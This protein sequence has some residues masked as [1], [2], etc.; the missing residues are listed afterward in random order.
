MCILNPGWFQTWLAH[1]TE[2]G[3][4]STL[5]AIIG[6]NVWNNVKKDRETLHG[7]RAELTLQRTNCLTTIQHQGAEQIQLLEKIVSNNA[8]L[9]GYIRGVLDGWKEIRISRR[10]NEQTKEK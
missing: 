9:N 8:E 7:I 5:L 10:D 1:F 3:V 6:R 4:V 2:G